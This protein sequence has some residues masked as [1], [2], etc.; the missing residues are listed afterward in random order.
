MSALFRLNWKDLLRGLIVTSLAAGLSML[1][2]ALRVGVI[3]WRNVAVA[4]LSAAIGY[5]IKNLLTDDQNKFVGKWQ[6]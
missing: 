4:A 2:E 3:D 6:L 1:L 5:I